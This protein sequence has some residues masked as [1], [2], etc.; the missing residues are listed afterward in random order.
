MEKIGGEKEEKDNG[1]PPPKKM[2]GQKNKMRYEK[3]EKK[4]KRVGVCRLRVVEEGK[5]KWER[6]D[7]EMGWL[8]IGVGSGELQGESE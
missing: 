2:G 5:K 7:E 8:G 1:G 3:R 4:E 6:G